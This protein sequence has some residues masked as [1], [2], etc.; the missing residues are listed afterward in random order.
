MTLHGEG[1]DPYRLGRGDAFVTPPGMVDALW[2]DPT[3]RPRTLEVSLP[4]S[5]H[6]GVL[7]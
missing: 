4:G 1:K 3:R 6:D 5:F 7:I 2:A